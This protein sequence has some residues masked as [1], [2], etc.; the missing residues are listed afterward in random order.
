M[1]LAPRSSTVAK[2]SRTGAEIT[3]VIACSLNM[4]AVR[5]SEAFANPVARSSGT[6]RRIPPD[7]IR[8]LLPRADRFCGAGPTRY[9]FLNRRRGGKPG[10]R[11]G[12]AARKLIRYAGF[13]SW[14]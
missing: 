3:A 11:N 12:H 4:W 5:Y 7:D 1:K 8:S 9:A 6:S 10:I 14:G 13:H 2:M